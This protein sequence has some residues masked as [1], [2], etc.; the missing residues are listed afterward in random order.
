MFGEDAPLAMQQFGD[1]IKGVFD[2]SASQVEGLG[3][4]LSSL[5]G[6]FQL[7]GL[8]ISSGL[9]GPL[10]MA[11]LTVGAVA[12]AVESFRASMS[13][14]NGPK[15]GSWG[16]EDNGP[17][18]MHGDKGAAVQP[19]FD[20]SY[21]GA[22]SV[23]GSGGGSGSKWW[24]PI[25]E[26]F[27]KP[28][29]GS[30]AINLGNLPNAKNEAGSLAESINK[31][32]VV[33][34]LKDAMAKLAEDAKAALGPLLDIFGK[35]GVKDAAKKK[36]ESSKSDLSAVVKSM[37]DDEAKIR[38]GMF[39]AMSEGVDAINEQTRKQTEGLQESSR[40][41]W[42]YQKGKDKEHAE[43]ARKIAEEQEQAMRN[44]QAKWQALGSGSIGTAAGVDGLGGAVLNQVGQAAVANSQYLG[45]ALQGAAAGAE[46]GGTAGPIGALVGALIGLA[47]QSNE[48]K[49]IMKEIDQILEAVVNALG[50][51][52]GAFQ[53]LFDSLSELAGLFDVIGSIL[54]VLTQ[55]DLGM[56]A[57]TAIFKALEGVDFS[58]ATKWF[59]DAG[60]SVGDWFSGEWI[61]STG[62][63]DEAYKAKHEAEKEAERIAKE[64]K[65]FQH[66]VDKASATG[67]TEFD[68]SIRKARVDTV[69]LGDAEYQAKAKAEYFAT[70]LVS[71]AQAGIDY[72]NQLDL[73][74]SAQGGDQYIQNAIDAAKLEEQKA[75]L[76][77]IVA[78][79][80]AALGIGAEKA[81]DALAKF[82]D[83]L[84]NEAT[85]YR[86][87]ATRYGSTSE[88]GPGGAGEA[89]IDT[90][91]GGG[92]GIGG[93]PGTTIV[94]TLDGAEIA[95]RIE[96]RRE[97]AQMAGVST[98]ARAPMLVGG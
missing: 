41:L 22:V 80:L 77:E 94:V 17:I 92:L 35:P 38:E 34:P 43:Y 79:R 49:A 37:Y 12:L 42:E 90:H 4:S 2:L 66:D 10:G 52:V 59:D 73:L 39:V 98:F 81:I 15:G 54:G 57:L 31:F 65:E 93:A 13:K 9:I 5:Q 36:A 69:L 63:V 44:E 11:L 33:A 78:D 68:E 60:K 45:G 20:P 28:G 95:H 88:G 87:G 30:A 91:M 6:A 18:R 58:G 76:D 14:V 23:G 25:K 51:V 7:V 97:R 40:E 19:L 46:A 3:Q 8:A 47:T 1:K 89:Q 48:F 61:F 70:T 53:D 64:A 96:R 29:D 62:A 67:M 27:S 26:W 71:M 56:Q 50:K 86:L 85:G 32:E 55:F 75:K 74:K 72:R 82:S 83:S 84:I 16:T 24:D 21:K